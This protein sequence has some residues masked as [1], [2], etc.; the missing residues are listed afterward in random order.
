VRPPPFLLAGEGDRSQPP[1]PAVHLRSDGPNLNSSRPIPAAYRRSNGPGP[2]PPHPAS[3]PIGPRLS[4]ARVRAA[5]PAPPVSRPRPRCP[6]GPACQPPAPA[7]PVRPRLSVARVRAARPAPP[8][9][10]PRPRCPA[11]PACQPA[12]PRCPPGPACQPLRPPRARAPARGS[13]PER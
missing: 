9:S 4:A 7:L 5:R 11:G 2:L 12:A 10:H 8:V 13:N 3:L 1:I 6:P